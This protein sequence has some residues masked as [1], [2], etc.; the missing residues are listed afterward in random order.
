M[1]TFIEQEMKYLYTTTSQL[2][3]YYQLMILYNTNSAVTCNS[4]TFISKRIQR[5]HV[6]EIYVDVYHHYYKY[7]FL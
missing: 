1:T 2:N 5:S 3:N 4:C 6:I 7:N